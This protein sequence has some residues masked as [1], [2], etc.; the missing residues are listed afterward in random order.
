MCEALERKKIIKSKMFFLG[1]SFL[2]RMQIKLRNPTAV[3]KSAINWFK[4][5]LKPVKI[6]K[7]KTKMKV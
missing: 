1:D 4:S 6:D 5:Q 2:K 3:K 7:T